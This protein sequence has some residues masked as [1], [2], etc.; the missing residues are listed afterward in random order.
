MKSEII[1]R[2]FL[3]DDQIVIEELIKDVT[4]KYLGQSNIDLYIHTSKSYVLKKIESNLLAIKD[5]I[6]DIDKKI[7]RDVYINNV[8]Y[9]LNIKQLNSKQDIGIIDLD[10]MSS[11]EKTNEMSGE[12][13]IVDQLF[14]YETSVIDKSKVTIHMYHK[15]LNREWRKEIDMSN[16][17]NKFSLKR[18]KIKSRL[19]ELISLK[20]EPNN[21]DTKEI[22]ELLGLK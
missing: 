10:S 11:G 15:N 4:F 17:R 1:K 7:V 2:A 13:D 14:A 5:A 22:I 16:I 19:K 21:N 9:E 12:N 6:Y 8:K 20:Y 3:N 18:K